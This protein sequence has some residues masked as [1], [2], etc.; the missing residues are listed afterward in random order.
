MKSDDEIA[1]ARIRIMAYL[2]EEEHY[3][4]DIHPYSGRQVQSSLPTFCQ[5]SS[6]GTLYTV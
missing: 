4:G 5:W 2:K 3:S 1:Q 6:Y